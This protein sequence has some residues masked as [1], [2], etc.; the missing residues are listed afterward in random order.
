MQL[1]FILFGFRP[2]LDIKHV[3]CQSANVILQ[4]KIPA[5]KEI[6]LAR[7]FAVKFRHAANG[8]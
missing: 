5:R 8:A 4:Q 2:S 7:E 3:F 1:R 6:L